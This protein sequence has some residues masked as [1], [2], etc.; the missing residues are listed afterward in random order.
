MANKVIGGTPRGN[1]SLC[2][3]C[4][5]AHNI[6][7]VNM[8]RITVC[9]SGQSFQVRFPVSECSVYDDKRMPALYQM[10]DIAWEVKSRSHGPAGFAGKND[11]SIVISPP[12]PSKNAPQPS[13]P[14]ATEPE[15]H[16]NG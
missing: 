13:T 10:Q 15:G 12:D 1:E 16:T 9:R 4:R 2:V 5:M 14:T 7:G 8:Q 11:L 6:V 3:T